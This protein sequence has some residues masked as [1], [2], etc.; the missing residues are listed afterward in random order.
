MSVEAINKINKPIVLLGMMGVG[1]T[2]YGK[3]L[4]NTLRVPFYDIDQEI[5]NDIGHAVSWIFENIGEPEFRRLEENKIK[6]LIAKHDRSIIAL[7]GGAFLNEKSRKLIKEK[8]ISVWLQSSAKVIY[9]RVSVRKD[10]PLLEGVSDKLG[11][12]KEISE[13]RAPIYAEAD[14]SLNTDTG[15]PKEINRNIIA[16]LGEFIEK[17][18]ALHLKRK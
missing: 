11:K 3:K 13:A 12:I 16:K 18:P 14:L 9:D 5:E 4:A 6:D 2:T 1:K 7:G 10:R 17:Q 15:G 8:T